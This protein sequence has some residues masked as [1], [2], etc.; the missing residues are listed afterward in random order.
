M[1]W[2]LLASGA[3]RVDV[4]SSSVTIAT[5]GADLLVVAVA[6]YDNVAV[7]VLSD[8]VGGNN[9]G[10]FNGLT[11]QGVSGD[12]RVRLYYVK[13]THVGASHVFTYTN[14]GSYSSIAVEAWSGSNTSNPYPG[15]NE[16]GASD[17]NN[18]HTT[19]QPGSL[20]PANDN[21]LIVTALSLTTA[22]FSAPTINQSF[23]V[24]A[25][26][27]GGANNFG[28]TIAS[29][30]QAGT[31]TA[32]NPTWTH[33]ATY[34]NAVIAAFKPTTGSPPSA[35]TSPDIRGVT[36]TGFTY[37]FDDGGQAS[38]TGGKF[39]YDTAS[40]FSASP[41]TLDFTLGGGTIT[42]PS[43]VTEGQ[44]YYGRFALTN[45]SGTSAYSTGV[46]F[47][48]AHRIYYDPI[49]D[50]GNIAWATAPL[51]SKLAKTS[52]YPATPTSNPAIE[53]SQDTDCTCDIAC[54]TLEADT[55]NLSL[56]V[57][58]NLNDFGTATATLLASLYVNGSPVGTAK[59][60]TTSGHGIARVQ[61]DSKTFSGTFHEGDTL[62]IRLV[63]NDL[64]AGSMFPGE[65]WQAYIQVGAPASAGSSVG[66]IGGINRLGP[67]RTRSRGRGI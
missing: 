40:D 30:A 56:V 20:T 59:S 66:A 24:D 67:F 44:Q 27:V 60:I 41:V 49:S 48:P 51:F 65:I 21:S 7:G 26:Q 53:F 62:A 50:I 25:T 6:D 54:G 22:G 31:A 46:G 61:W 35:P 33:S 15:S 29:L 36:L 32:V 47:I 42:F 58:S 5:T 28:L 16:N 8:S 19:L 4:N 11:A 52:R 57:Y 2:T 12:S 13:P 55:G 3:G 9:N 17:S 14:T 38:L 10:T 1:S 39:Q 63:V 37:F 34:A 23:A 64:L 43:A 45:A 18:A